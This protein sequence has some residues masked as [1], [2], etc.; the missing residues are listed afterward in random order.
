M[1]NMM[2][3]GADSNPLMKNVQKMATALRKINMDQLQRNRKR[4]RETNCN[5]QIR[6]SKEE[7]KEF[8]WCFMYIKEITLTENYIAAYELW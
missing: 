7:M 5:K 4:P 1:I 6:W 2:E 3:D 8:V